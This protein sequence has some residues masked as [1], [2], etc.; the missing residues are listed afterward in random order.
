MD[1]VYQAQVERRSWNE[2][3]EYLWQALSTK[4]GGYICS[5]IGGAK[6]KLRNIKTQR[7]RVVEFTLSNPV[8]V[9]ERN[10]E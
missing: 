7:C 10:F 1:K 2:D 4:S 8:V 3:A 5:S 9:E 6:S